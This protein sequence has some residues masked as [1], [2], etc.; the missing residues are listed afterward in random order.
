MYI[1]YM[2]IYI[3]IYTH[4]M[5]IY[6]YIYM[7]TYIMYNMLLYVIVCYIMM[8][9]D[10]IYSR[11]APAAPPCGAESTAGALLQGEGFSLDGCPFHARGAPF[12]RTA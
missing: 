6:I 8:Q 10:M 11:R 3:Y 4:I 9:Y 2:C 7:H 1:I 12:F 5:H